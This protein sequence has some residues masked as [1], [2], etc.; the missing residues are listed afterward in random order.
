[1]TIY[2]SSLSQEQL[3]EAA[4]RDLERKATM[5]IVGQ[6]RKDRRETEIADAMA[7]LTDCDSATVNDPTER[8]ALI[9]K[10]K[11]GSGANA[12]LTKLLQSCF[13]CRLVKGNS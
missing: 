10:V 9:A 3:V 6:R 13:L 7:R 12:R 2:V 5:K 8:A 1:M 11:K 4:R